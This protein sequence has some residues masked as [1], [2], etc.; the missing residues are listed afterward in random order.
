[1]K[2]I[3]IIPARSGSKRIPKK[4]IKLFL[5]Q[6]IIS[7]S[8]SAALESNLFD[9]IMVSTDSEEIAD[10]AISYGAKTPFYRSKKNSNDYASTIDVLKEVLEYYSKQGINFEYGCCLYPA[11]PFAKKKLLVETYNFMIKEKSDIVFPVVAYSHPIQRAFKLEKSNKINLLNREYQNSRSQ[12]LESIYHDS[13]QFYWFKTHKLLANNKMYTNNTFGY[14][15]SEN[16]VQ[17]IDNPL[18][19]DIAEMKY[20][21]LFT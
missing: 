3:C 2:K 20:K 6:P 12:D 5:G 14:I 16:E 7:Y 11:A 1:M 17:D 9:E 13:G 21:N 8:I 10:I 18:D 19:W 4:N 15:L